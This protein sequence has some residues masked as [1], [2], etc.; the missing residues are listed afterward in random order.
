MSVLV[1]SPEHINALI[2][3]ANKTNCC[4]FVTY[5]DETGA[6]ISRVHFTHYEDLERAADLIASSNQRAYCERYREEY[7]PEEYPFFTLLPNQ[8][9]PIEI[10]KLCD[11]ARYNCSEEAQ[12]LIQHIREHAIS[13]IP[14][15]S[16]APWTI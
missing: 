11:C 12:D 5:N 13:L 7:T 2:S 3:W 4:D 6:P 1:L 14:G 8:L 15:Y 16:S 9:S 10:V